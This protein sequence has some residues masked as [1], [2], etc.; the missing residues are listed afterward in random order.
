MKDGLLGKIQSLI[1]FFLILFFGISTIIYT[2]FFFNSKF[3]QELNIFHVLII[4]ISIVLGYVFYRYSE[5]RIE[6]IRKPSMETDKKDKDA[7]SIICFMLGSLAI[8]TL[9]K[10]AVTFY[11]INNV[12]AT[13]YDLFLDLLIV[14]TAVLGIVGVAI[15]KWIFRKIDIYVKEEI[16]KLENKVELLSLESRHFT[17]AQTLK[18]AGYL[19]YSL[20][21]SLY[22]ECESKDEKDGSKKNLKLAI[23]YTKLAK[24]IAKELK[25]DEGKN[26]V[27]CGIISNNLAFYLATKWACM[28]KAKGKED[29]KKYFEDGNNRDKYYDDE[30]EAFLCL[31]VIKNE[32]V[33]KKIP[34]EISGIISKDIRY[35]EGILFKINMVVLEAKKEEE[36]QK[37]PS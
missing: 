17:E 33:R 34:D 11:N 29:L 7:F 35:V 15:Y 12:D 5:K 22:S 2:T 27:L 25:V 1:L 28:E 3:N 14:I 6:E 30:K 26:D 16:I 20:Y 36:Q 18:N 4:A 9:A 31:K 21:D 10:L 32:E 13:K 8:I 23:D 24:R 37:K 19:H